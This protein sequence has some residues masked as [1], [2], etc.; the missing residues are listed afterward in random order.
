VH[1]GLSDRVSPGVGRESP[2]S[3]L[4]F[5]NPWVMDIDGIRWHSRRP[6]SRPPQPARAAADRI[7]DGWWKDPRAAA[8]A[9]G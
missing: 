8:R 2:F 5:L 7:R 4:F 1:G 6:V 9:R 3:G